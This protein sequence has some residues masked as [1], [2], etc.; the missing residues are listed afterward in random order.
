MLLAPARVAL[1][2]GLLA[3]GLGYA[4]R[5]MTR[6]SLLRFEE[7]MALR[8]DDNS[9]EVKALLPAIVVS[10]KPAFEETKAWYPTA[11]LTALIHVFGASAL[12]SC[13]A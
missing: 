1:L 4:Q 9:R 12:R 2:L 6:N 8:R 7:T 3:P 5:E 10:V 13:E 11:A